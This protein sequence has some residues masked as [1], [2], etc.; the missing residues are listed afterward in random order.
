M[1]KR[2]RGEDLSDCCGGKKKMPEDMRR[3]WVDFVQGLPDQVDEFRTGEVDGFDYHILP[4][5]FDLEWTTDTS[6]E[7]VVEAMI[8][9]T[10][11]VTYLL[12][13]LLPR[14]NKRE[15]NHS[16]R[17]AQLFDYIN[18]N[19]YTDYLPLYVREECYQNREFVQDMDSRRNEAFLYSCYCY[20][21]FTKPLEE[22]QTTKRARFCQTLLLDYGDL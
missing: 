17:N 9:V 14:G 12:H 8:E 19:G 16:R 5:S 3:R 7:R 6:C 1:V 18:Q 13:Y 10:L 15:A 20:N 2:S 4:R 22:E 21:M 11:R